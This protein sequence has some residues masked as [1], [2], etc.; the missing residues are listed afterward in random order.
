M[1]E[2]PNLTDAVPKSLQSFSQHDQMIDHSTQL[3]SEIAE[4]RKKRKKQQ[5]VHEV[6]KIGKAA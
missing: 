6:I 5:K 1:K 4:L 2:E 3:Q